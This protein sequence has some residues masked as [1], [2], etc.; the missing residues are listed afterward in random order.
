MGRESNVEERKK[1]IEKEIPPVSSSEP[2]EKL[3]E[4][5][6]LA[7]L[8]RSNPEEYMKYLMTHLDELNGKNIDSTVE[9]IFKEFDEDGSG[10]LEGEEYEKCVQKLAE[11]I[12]G[13]Y[14][15]H[16]EKQFEKMSGELGMSKEEIDVIRS[17]HKETMTIEKF[18]KEVIKLVDVDGD[19]KITLQ[20]A[21]DGFH[22]VV[23]AIE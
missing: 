20:E 8:A 16:M 6:E 7:E 11:H 3:D 5:K 9:S 1:D 13:E 17:E 23:D 18:K 15:E 10:V 21:M 22:K 14:D 19:G 12:L 4:Q 2:S